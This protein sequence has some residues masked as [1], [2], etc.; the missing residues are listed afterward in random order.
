MVRKKRVWLPASVLAFFF[1][2]I[3]V[4]SLLPQ[5]QPIDLTVP[6][7]TE[8]QSVI[9]KMYQLQRDLVCQ[10]ETDVN[11]LDEVMKDTSDYHPTSKQRSLIE[12]VYGAVP[13]SHA[14][15][16]TT[17]KALFLSRHSINLSTSDPGINPTA[18]PIYY[19]PEIHSKVNVRLTAISLE[20]NKAIVRYESVGGVHEAVLRKI[21][22]HWVITSIKLIK[23]WG[24]MKACL[25]QEPNYEVFY[26]ITAYTL[27]ENELTHLINPFM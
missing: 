7:A 16:L 3:L 27:L 4:Y 19:C 12:K 9:T 24:G 6:L 20:K 15:Y 2:S 14:G 18:P 13:L 26:K 17:Q 1:G 11:V 10:R 22:D 23:W 21:G 8:F 5:P 25:S